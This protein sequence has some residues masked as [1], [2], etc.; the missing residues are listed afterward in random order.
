[1]LPSITVFFAVF[2]SV[3]ATSFLSGIFGM[4]GG[5]IL[6]GL[7]LIVLPVPAAMSLHAVTQMAANGWRAVLW[8]RH[9]IW[10]VVPGYLLG[11]LFIFGFFAWASFTPPSAAVYLFLGAVP[12]SL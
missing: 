6:M 10:K 2:S 11:A 12:I 5:L 4:L 1:M 8:H 7:L 3:L 9:L